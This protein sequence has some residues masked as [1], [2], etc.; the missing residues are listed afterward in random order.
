MAMVVTVVATR[1]AEADSVCAVY[2]DGAGDADGGSEGSA[3]VGS[4]CVGSACVGSGHAASGGDLHP[5]GDDRTPSQQER[6]R[7][8]KTDESLALPLASQRTQRSEQPAS[9]MQAIARKC[10]AFTASV[11][12]NARGENVSQHAPGP[13]PPAEPR[14]QSAVSGGSKARLLWTRCTIP[15]TVT[16]KSC[17]THA[18]LQ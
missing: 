16:R 3:R 8:Q 9:R 12:P 2:A 11:F 14:S 4:V 15:V 7:K 5:A 13:A 1:E 18:S 10:T 17:T 6:A